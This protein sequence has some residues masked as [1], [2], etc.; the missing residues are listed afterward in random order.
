M[1]LMISKSKDGNGYYTKLKN[2]YNGKHIEKYLTLQIPK[3]TELEYGLYETEGFLSPYQ[4]KDG[5]VEFKLVVTSVFPVSKDTKKLGDNI[6]T[7]SKIGEQ[8]EIS[9]EDFPF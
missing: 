1:K 3:G 2:D 7:Q 9:P 4:K 5:S 8:I 6:K